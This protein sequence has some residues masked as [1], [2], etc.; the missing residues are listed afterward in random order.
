MNGRVSHATT[1]LKVL[2]A[3]LEHVETHFRRL[4]KTAFLVF[5]LFRRQS[6][7]VLR[8]RLLAHLPLEESQ[9]YEGA[10]RLRRL[11]QHL[12]DDVARNGTQNRQLDVPMTAVT[13]TLVQ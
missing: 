10:L 12:A 8:L 2:G 7:L 5:K 3:V 1:V 4:V 13:Q 6:K 11:G 9:V